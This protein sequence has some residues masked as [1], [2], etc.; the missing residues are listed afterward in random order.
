[1]TTILL[2]LRIINYD[3]PVSV[4]KRSNLNKVCRIN[5]Y[6]TFLNIFFQLFIPLNFQTL[7]RKH[8]MLTKFKLS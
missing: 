7:F 4:E 8:N 6:G 3:D 5:V 1:M 2:Y